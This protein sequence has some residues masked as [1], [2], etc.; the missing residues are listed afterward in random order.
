[1]TATCITTLPLVTRMFLLGQDRESI[2]NRVLVR[3][4]TGETVANPWNA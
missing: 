1:M 4:R 2:K 3:R